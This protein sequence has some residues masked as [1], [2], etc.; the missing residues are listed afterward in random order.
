MVIEFI[1][2]LRILAL[3]ASMLVIGSARAEPVMVRVLGD[4]DVRKLD[5]PEGK[6]ATVNVFLQSFGAELGGYEV[7]IYRDRDKAQLASVVSDENGEVSF[8]GLPSGEYTLVVELGGR[9]RN[10][11]EGIVKIGD[12]RLLTER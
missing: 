2:R 9:R 10:I 3:I 12:V 5:L 1:Q 8:T 4:Y 11:R 6:T 7:V